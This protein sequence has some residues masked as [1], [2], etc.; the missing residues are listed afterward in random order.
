MFDAADC[1]TTINVFSTIELTNVVNQSV[2]CLSDNWVA[3]AFL[4]RCDLTGAD[5]GGADLRFAILTVAN[6]TG[7]D[8]RGADLTGTELTDVVWSDTTC[9]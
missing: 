5:L 8:L 6:L 3:G 9:P 7:A 1:T 4:S 2:V